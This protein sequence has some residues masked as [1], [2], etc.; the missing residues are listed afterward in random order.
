[1]MKAPFRYTGRTLQPGVTDARGL[2]ASR[3]DLG[4]PKVARWNGRPPLPAGYGFLINDDGRFLIDFDR[5]YVI[6]PLEA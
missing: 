6:V 1:M 4:V 2:S 5:R 3:I